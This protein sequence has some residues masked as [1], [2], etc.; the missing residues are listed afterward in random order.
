MREASAFL[1]ERNGAIDQAA[2]ELFDVIEDGVTNFT[3]NMLTIASPG[4]IRP[5]NFNSM[6]DTQNFQDVKII[7]ERHLNEIS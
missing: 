3:K 5:P 4:K 6:N 7:I 2:G 1:L